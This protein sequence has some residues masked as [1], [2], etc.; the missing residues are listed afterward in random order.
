MPSRCLRMV[1]RFHSCTACAARLFIDQ[2][3]PVGAERRHPHVAQV[4]ARQPRNR[5]ARLGLD[6]AK[7]L[8]RVLDE[9]HPAIGGKTQT[10]AADLPPL[11]PGPDLPEPAW[12]IRRHQPF[13]IGAELNPDETI[14]RQLLHARRIT[15]APD[16]GAVST[17]AAGCDPLS[18]RADGNT[19]DVVE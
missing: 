1:R 17:M 8:V 15:H 3:R 11:A 2:A 12:R 5:V 9:Q 10:F 6:Q 13:P 4:G 16:L 18:V 19:A 14:D 7:D